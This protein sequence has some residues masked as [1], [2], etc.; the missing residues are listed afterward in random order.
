MVFNF[1]GLIW[2]FTLLNDLSMNNLSS[3]QSEIFLWPVVFFVRSDK[4]K[5]FTVFISWHLREVG[6]R[7]LDHF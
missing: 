1:T 5:V 7:S 2:L 3:S 4:D 6:Y